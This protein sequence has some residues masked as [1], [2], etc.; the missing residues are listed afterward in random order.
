MNLPSSSADKSQKNWS[1]KK[2]L[3]FAKNLQLALGDHPVVNLTGA[4]SVGI[5]LAEGRPQFEEMYQSADLALY[6][7]KK[8]GKHGFYLHHG[9]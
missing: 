8:A 4:E 6:R 9:A 3:R 5:S 2:A 1:A 7:A